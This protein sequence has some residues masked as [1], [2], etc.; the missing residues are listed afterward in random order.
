MEEVQRCFSQSMPGF[1]NKPSC[2]I[3]SLFWASFSIPA[4]LLKP[5]WSGRVGSG[6]QEGRCSHGNGSCCLCKEAKEGLFS[7][8]SARERCGVCQ[9]W[10][11]CSAEGSC[12]LFVTLSFVSRVQSLCAGQIWDNLHCKMSLIASAI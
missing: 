8:L 7:W 4:L 6:L 5:S 12:C 3:R 10:L 1:R 9:L 2:I 11:S